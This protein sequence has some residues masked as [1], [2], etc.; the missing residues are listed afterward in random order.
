MCELCAILLYLYPNTHLFTCAV[1]VYLW[2]PGGAF[3]YY[4]FREG[5]FLPSWLLKHILCF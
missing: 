4:F 5:S 2:F 1:D 3:T